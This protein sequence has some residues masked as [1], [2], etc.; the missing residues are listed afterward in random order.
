MGQVQ[1]QSTPRSLARAKVLN[2]TQ[3]FFT[4]TKLCQTS[5]SI[6]QSYKATCFWHHYYLLFMAYMILK[7]RL[8][9]S[10]VQLVSLGRQWSQSSWVAPSMTRRDPG[11]SGKRM[12]LGGPFFR[13]NSKTLTAPSDT[14]EKQVDLQ[15]KFDLINVFTIDRF[16]VSLPICLSFSLDQAFF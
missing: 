3:V 12:K 13:R 7:V 8:I 1:L 2:N 9:R 4:R 11:K 15:P 16:H 6:F 14:E 5:A 10:S